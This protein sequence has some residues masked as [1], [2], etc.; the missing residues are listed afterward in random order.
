MDQKPNVN[1]SHI[2]VVPQPQAA[3]T[4][5]PNSSNGWDS[6]SSQAVK[7]GAD[8]GVGGY[9]G[10]TLPAAGDTALLMDRIIALENTENAFM[11]DSRNVDMSQ[12]NEHRTN[13]ELSTLERDISALHSS[14]QHK[15]QLLRS[16][17]NLSWLRFRRRRSIDDLGRI[18]ICGNGMICLTPD[19]EP[20]KPQRLNS[21]GLTYE[22]R[23]EILGEIEDIDRSI[24]CRTR[25]VALSPA[26]HPNTPSFLAGLGSSYLRRFESQGLLSDLDRSI[27]FLHQA[28]S[29]TPHGDPNITARLNNLGLSYQSRFEHLGEPDDLEKALSYINQAMLL[30]PDDHP[31]KPKW[32]NNLGISYHSRF[33]LLEE[34][35]DLEKAINCKEEAVLLSRDSDPD[36]P[37]RLS[38]LSISY[39]IRFENHG[40]IEDIDKAIKY[41]AQAITL[42]DH[43]HVHKPDWLN[44]LGSSYRRRFERLGEISD[45]DQAIKYEEQALLLTPNHQISKPERLNNLGNA[46]LC[47]FEFLGKQDDIKNAAVFQEQA[48]LLT[49]DDHPNKPRF[50]S[51][52]GNSLLRLFQHLGNLEDASRAINCQEKALALQT[53]GNQPD[54]PTRLNSLGLIYTSLFE[55]FGKLGDIDKAIGFQ[56]QSVELVPD[57]HPVLSG[58]LWNLGNSHVHRFEKTANAIDTTHAIDCF[59]QAACLSTGQ[60]SVRLQAARNWAKLTAFENV[61]PLDAYKEALALMPQIVWLG[62]SINRRY[63][64]LIADAGTVATEAA[65]AAIKWGNDQ[66]ALEWLDEGRSVVWGQRTQ[67]QDPF[68]TLWAVDSQL[69]EKLKLVAQELEGRSTIMLAKSSLEDNVLLEEAAQQQHRLAA[70]WDHLLEQARRLPGLQNF[71]RPKSFYELVH[72]ARDSTVVVINVHQNQCDGIALIPGSAQPVHISLPNFS[73]EKALEVHHQL[74]VSLGNRAARSNT[75]RQPIFNPESTEDRFQDALATIWTDIVEVILGRLGYL[76]SRF[77]HD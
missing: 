38:N 3:L 74:M 50:L 56:K 28:I 19:D 35:G 65:A 77:Q 70:S 51:S 5:H 8:A 44:N 61:S 4:D 17:A 26:V 45:I 18:I 71:L 13:Q 66:L 62:S 21:L 72:A 7:A 2:G 34:V 16:L 40:K 31:S 55:R 54:K 48:V 43:S 25:A 41:A 47:R 24:E 73:D 59:K 9:A 64:Q 15:L 1:P 75:T 23:F 12:L 33:E 11:S 58:W 76:V 36:K 37:A 14:H 6:P 42:I 32:L 60:P 53:R 67:L 27:D 29:S 57:N 20:E 22:R 63:E 49:P 30:A 39:Q 69:A 68:H 10:E 46:Y 52:L